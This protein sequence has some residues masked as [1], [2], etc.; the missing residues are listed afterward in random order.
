MKVEEF[1]DLIEE[2]GWDIARKELEKYDDL[3]D[4]KGNESLVKAVVYSDMVCDEDD[5]KEIV[6]KILKY[7]IGTFENES[8]F[9]DYYAD[10]LGINECAKNFIDWKKLMDS[11]EYEYKVLYGDCG[12][13]FVFEN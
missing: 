11:L 7:H 6:D 2:E 4:W 12:G 5:T 9:L 10:S 1:K 8:E 3:T 13:V